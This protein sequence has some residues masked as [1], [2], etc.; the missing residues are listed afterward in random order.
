VKLGLLTAAFPDLSLNEVAAWSAANGFE[1]LEVACWPSSGGEARR[2]AG[3][4]HIDVDAL[5]VDAVRE[6]LARH[7]LAISSLAYYPNNLHPDDS[8]REQVNAHLR[9][10]IDAAQALGVGIVGTFAGNDK[11]RPLPE[12]LDRFRRIWP[13]LVAYA[14]DRDVKIAIENC[15]MI[16]SYDEWPGGT[17][18]AWSP[19]IWDEMFSAVPD[20]NFG[21]NLDPSHL[22]WQMIDAERVV[23]EFGD[24]ILHAHGK[25]LE[26]R[27][28]GLYEHGVMSTGIGWQVPRLCGHGQVDWGRFIG[29][30][31]A[32]GYDGVVSIE[33]ED[34]RFEGDDE[35][36]K[37]GFV[38]A[39]DVLRPYIV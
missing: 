21:L 24:R 16:F 25:D 8:H 18:L 5:D 13:E 11:D 29:A 19:A 20:E 14:G 30:L 9:K 10:V 33:H 7:G 36:V 35:L 15:P 2:Y 32:V 4:T 1:M 22:V 28:D 12:N 26:V 17:N 39:R 38:L 27:P 34:R 37:R 23:H 3:V 31:Y 6:T